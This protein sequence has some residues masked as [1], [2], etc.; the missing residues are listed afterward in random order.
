M[1]LIVMTRRPPGRNAAS[2]LAGIG[3][4]ATATHRMSEFARRPL[5]VRRQ[6]PPRMSPKGSSL[7][8]PATGSRPSSLRAVAVSWTSTTETILV[9]IADAAP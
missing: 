3:P 1:P 9:R 6:S 4:A 7:T 5:N 2:R 8:L